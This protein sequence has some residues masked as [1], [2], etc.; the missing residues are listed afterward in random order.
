MLLKQKDYKRQPD[1]SS[2]Q[3]LTR[4]C[5]VLNESGEG[6]RIYENAAHEFPCKYYCKIY[7]KIHFIL[8]HTMV[9]AQ[10][11]R[12]GET[13]PDTDEARD[14][15]PPSDPAREAAIRETL[16]LGASQ[17]GG[18]SACVQLTNSPLFEVIQAEL[19]EARKS[20]L[21][22]ADALLKLQDLSL[23][24]IIDLL[25]STSLNIDSERILLLY[26]SELTVAR[27]II[28]G[29][30]ANIADSIPTLRV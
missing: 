15:A 29:E 30:L 3:S 16:G 8:K 20:V 25:N 27:M 6:S 1:Y 14:P 5:A 26:G 2:A 28:A 13:Y 18:T 23:E 12:D 7:N 9:I 24:Q 10:L 21:S 4:D 17:L 11:Y 19:E 22:V